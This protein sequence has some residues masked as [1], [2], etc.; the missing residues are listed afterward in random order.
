VRGASWCGYSLWGCLA[1][2]GRVSLR[3]GPIWGDAQQRWSVPPSICRFRPRSVGIAWR[4]SGD[5]SDFSVRQPPSSIMPPECRRSP[6]SGGLGARIFS[7]A[8]ELRP[9]LF[10]TVIGADPNSLML[11]PSSRPGGSRFIPRGN[12]HDQGC[13]GSRIMWVLPVKAWW[14][15]PRWQAGFGRPAGN[16]LPGPRSWPY[17]PDA[18]VLKLRFAASPR[19]GQRQD[20]PGQRPHRTPQICTKHK[21]MSCRELRPF[22]CKHSGT[23]QSR[24]TLYTSARMPIRPFI[25]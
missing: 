16:Q 20:T 10:S 15:D 24:V 22:R 1:A 4:W 8:G 13:P 21:A 17:Q 11:P 7:P 9:N 3:G 12:R 18:P 14:E 2:A 25:V 5:S 6:L 23:D 19:R